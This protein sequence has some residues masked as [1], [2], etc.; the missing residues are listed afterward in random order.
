MFKRLLDCQN[1]DQVALMIVDFGFN[2][3]EENRHLQKE[4][5]GLLKKCQNAEKQAKDAQLKNSEL[6]RKL[7]ELSLK[8]DLQRISQS[9]QL[10]FTQ[11]KN[12]Q[13][14]TQLSELGNKLKMVETENDR[15]KQEM[16]K[17]NKYKMVERK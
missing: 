9:Q 5:A 4:K 2:R 6:D 11:T 7:G 10:I 12:N 16:C 15:L 14:E 1:P 17:T 13:L 3:K 8:L